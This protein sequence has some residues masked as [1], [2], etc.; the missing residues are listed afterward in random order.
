M[1]LFLRCIEA[2]P[3]PAVCV[4]AVVDPSGA[5][6]ENVFTGADRSSS[7]KNSLL[8]S[9]LIIAPESHVAFSFWVTGSEMYGETFSFSF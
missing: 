9:T 5:A 2:L 6:F 7:S 1:R 8:F 4:R 3:Y